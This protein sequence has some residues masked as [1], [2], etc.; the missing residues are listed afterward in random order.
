MAN[1]ILAFPNYALPQVNSNYSASAATQTPTVSGGSWNGAL[2]AS[3]LVLGSLATP[4][5]STDATSA[6]TQFVID[7]QVARPLSVFALIRHNLTPDLSGT[8]ATWRV[9]L[10]NVSNFAS[11]VYT[12]AF[13]NAYQPFWA[14]GSLPTG[15]TST[16][17]G[18][19]R[20]DLAQ[21][22]SFASPIV[23]PQVFSAR[24]IK[25]EIVDTGNSLGYIQ[26]GGFFAGPGFQPLVNIQ[27]GAQLGWEDLS[28][29]SEGWG[30]VRFYQKKPRRRTA[31]FAFQAVRQDQGMEVL[32]EMQPA[33]GTTD[34][35]FFILDPASANHLNRWSFLATVKQLSPLQFPYLNMVDAAV[36]LVEVL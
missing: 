31:Q 1:A 34:P 25:V 35:C 6:N 33:I 7:L 27:Y 3:N 32:F 26:L 10:S 4:A 18:P 21:Y 12:S 2:P 28:Q 17:N 29:V 22:K 36:Q 30:G 24:Y 9:T 20:F 8:P 13:T 15:W 19:S 11:T 16:G 23:A 14:A 5:R